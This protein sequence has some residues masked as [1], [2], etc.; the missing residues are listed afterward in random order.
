MGS[1]MVKIG[2]LKIRKARQAKNVCSSGLRKS[3]LN[4]FMVLPFVQSVGGADGDSLHSAKPAVL[5]IE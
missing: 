3:V 2:Q 4:L 1:K 5:V